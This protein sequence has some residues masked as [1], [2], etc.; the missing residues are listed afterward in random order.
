MN[1]A[2]NHSRS[3]KESK[4]RNTL[5][6]RNLHESVTKKDLESHFG[7]IG[8]LRHAFLVTTRG[9][10]SCK[11]YGFVTFAFPED[12][13]RARTVLDQSLLKGRKI[14][15][16]VAQKRFRSNSGEPENRTPQDKGPKKAPIQS[17]KEKKNFAQGSVP[18]RT[19]LLRKLSSED[20]FTEE[21]ARKAV[22]AHLEGSGF[23][24]C[25]LT[26]DGKQARCM[27][28]S[29]SNAGKAAGRAHGG[30]IDA[31]I[32]ALKAGKRTKLI[33]RNLPF[34]LDEQQLRAEFEAIAPIRSL[35]LSPSSEL[36]RQE[37]YKTK[38]KAS[39]SV[40]GKDD[41]A[42]NFISC[43]G[44]AFIEYF[45][46]AHA[47]TAIKTLN[48]TK[49][50]GRVIAVDM[51]VSKSQ[52]VAQNASEELENPSNDADDLA[53]TEDPQKHP[54]KNESSASGP[55]IEN[56]PQVSPKEKQKHKSRDEQ[57]PDDQKPRQRKT[58][59][60]GEL[61]RT[62]FI[63]NL[64]FETSVPE[65]RKAVE[66]RFG[67]VQ[68]VLIVKNP[69][70]GRPRGTAFVIFKD[71]KTAREAASESQPEG[72]THSPTQATKEFVLHG[73]K[74]LLS[75]AVDRSTAKDLT[76]TV[77]LHSKKKQDSDPRNLRL[78]WVGRIAPDSKQAQGLSPDDISRREKAEKE[79]KTKLERNP[80]AFI[81]EVR[82]SV[83]NLPRE[84][85][86]KALKQIFLL[87]AQQNVANRQREGEGESESDVGFPKITHLAIVRDSERNGRSKGYGFVQFSEHRHALQ[88]LHHV[89]NNP[90][91]IEWLIKSKPKPLRIDETRAELLRRQWRNRR[92]IVEFAVEDKRIVQVLDRVRE[93]GK[94]R[95]GKKRKADDDNQELRA[96][97]KSKHASEGKP[98]K[99]NTGPTVEDPERLKSTSHSKSKRR[100]QRKR[101]QLKSSESANVTQSQNERREVS[102]P[103]AHV[104]GTERK[105]K[106]TRVGKVKVKESK[107]TAQDERFDHLVNVYKKKIA[108][109][110]ERQKSHSLKKPQTNN[111]GPSVRW[112]ETP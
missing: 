65:L 34:K 8:P 98:V 79:K 92:L 4:D 21:E 42:G 33:V 91:L 38:K 78:A 58:Q 16:D 54:T 18:M 64:L 62:V 93:K 17:T 43:A 66:E 6:V 96:R 30:A 83:R 32:E 2:K 99:N 112:F 35:R 76:S 73:R 60:A 19:V 105:S 97:K 28:D 50:G 67:N 39:D 49:I 80:N 1:S 56:Q 71:E 15:L 109:V 48:G 53:E 26:S 51:A 104:G 7:G 84:C 61:R 12:A 37:I 72:S 103:Q 5:F 45:L 63:R 13:D 29:W 81:S 110:H 36:R 9:S 82:L 55:H 22:G 52:Y 31:V 87:S 3:E 90:H 70:T 47:Q 95:A 68:R 25:V 14:S 100:F 69:V 85:D 89:N 23:Q 40:G 94:Q 46:V 108:S 107:K 27:Y 20:T 74:L 41:K 75:M 24:T 77:P 59:N 101:N 111:T 10:S 57:E 86:E 106:K 11:G 102:E 88:A 44:Y